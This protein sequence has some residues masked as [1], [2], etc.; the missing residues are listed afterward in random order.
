MMNT[1]TPDPSPKGEGSQVDFTEAVPLA[2]I[3]PEEEERAR[4]A[5]EAGTPL[6]V[7]VGYF[8]SLDRRRGERR[9]P[10]HGDRH[11]LLVVEDDADLAQLLIDVFMN[12]GFDVR[13]AANRAE[14]NAE[15]HRAGIDLVLLDIVLPD[16]DGL[17]VLRRLREHPRLSDLPVIMMTGKV[18]PEDVLAGLAAGADGYVTKPFKVSA[19]RNA[20]NAVLGLE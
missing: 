16:A 1:L 3:T 17:Q 19:L 6:L 8:L 4:R 9:A 14:I 5:A 20:V 11:S 18:A 13:W 2:A 15:L 7:K 10:V 12:A